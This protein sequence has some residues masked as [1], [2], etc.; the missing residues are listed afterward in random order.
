MKKTLFILIAILVNYCLSAQTV[1]R[2]QQIPELTPSLATKWGKAAMQ[3]DVIGNDFFTDQK[4][5]FSNSNRFHTGLDGWKPVDGFKRTLGGVAD[6]IYEFWE[7]N[8]NVDI[9][10]DMNSRNILP[11]FIQRY[12]SAV[13]TG[14]KEDDDAADRGLQIELD[15]YQSGGNGLFNSLPNRP[16]VKNLDAKPDTIFAFGPLVM[17]VNHDHKPEIHP[18]EQV[19]WRRKENSIDNHYLLF[20]CDQ[21]D[22]FDDKRDFDLSSAEETS[23]TPWAKRPLKGLFAIPFV[24]NPG[25]TKAQVT[26]I[27]LREKNSKDNYTDGKLHFLLYKSDTLAVVKENA[28]NKDRV[29]I[30]FHNICYGIGSWSGSVMGYV[31]L[32]MEAGKTNTG[33]VLDNDQGG[34]LFLKVQKEIIAV[35]QNKV[36]NSSS[37]TH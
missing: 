19:W 9:N 4:I 7:G 31:V 11:D 17:D 34:Y 36:N 21:S 3:N 37:I 32:Q 8:N 33:S 16:K 5:G 2:L 1:T 23:F 13:A 10:I 30:S 6:S 12:Q 22:R 15:L 29:K 35:P 26:I 24:I 28:N 14:L 20:S 18:A 25:K 27:T